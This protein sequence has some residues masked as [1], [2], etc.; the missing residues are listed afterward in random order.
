MP[1]PSRTPHAQESRPP[2][3]RRRRFEDVYAANRARILGYALRRTSDPQ[4]AADVLAETFLTAWRRL[5]DVPPGDEA[6]LW[7]YGVARRVLA[8]HHRGE[9]R[10]SALA[11]DLGSQVRDGLTGHDAPDG[12]L[13]GVGAAFRGLPESD[14]EL[15]ALV[16]WEGLDHGEIATVLGCSRNAVRIRLHRARR[17]FARAL[18]RADADAP[19]ASTPL[20]ATP[21]PTTPLPAAGRRIPNGDPT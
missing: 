20:P 7:L 1:S 9:R 5:D 16:G 10:R 18:A 21:L 3:D 17:R 11:A 2:D 19:A 12:D 13:A 4:D 14:R 15:L 8:N 6:R